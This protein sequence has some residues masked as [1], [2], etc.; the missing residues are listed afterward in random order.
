MNDDSSLDVWSHN[1]TQLPQQ[2][3]VM[4]GASNLSR[5]FPIAISMT[6]HVFQTP[7]AFYIAKG[8]GR[9]YGKVAS[10]FGKKNS[11]IFLSGIW[12]ALEQEKK[13]PTTA[14]LTDI[15]NDLAYE[16]PVETI[17]EWVE[18]CLDRLSALDARVVLSDLPLDVLR[19][20]GAARYRFVRRL[21]FPQCQLEWPELLCRAETLSERL[22]EVAESRQVPFFTGSNAW[23]GLDPIHPRRG[24][25]P[26]MWSQLLAHVADVPEDLSKHRC[27]FLLAWYLRGLRPEEWSIFSF[28]RRATQPNGWLREGS[29]LSLF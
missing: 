29:T 19:Q 27:P 12:R 26:E 10:C 9:S 4:L 28:S 25:Y 3:I 20:V 21:L 16:V 15:G 8:H 14:F 17:L 23:Y 11:G 13:L 7:L 1:E 22:R 5:A 6:Q 2:R 18:G 24:C